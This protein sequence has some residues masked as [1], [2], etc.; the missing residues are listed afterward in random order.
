MFKNYLK[1][2]VRT[3]T[4]NKIYTL[5]NVAGLALGIVCALAIFLII[6][7]QSSFDTYHEDLQ[8]IYRV[9]RTENEFGEINHSP[10]IPYPLPEALRNDFPNIPNLTIVDSNFGPPV[11]SVEKNGTT[12]RFKEKD[13]SV[14]FVNPDYFK[15]F[16]YKWLHGKCFVGLRGRYQNSIEV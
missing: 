14:A 16:K 6:K 4:K 12:F 1:T 2:T 10:G 8:N 9:V 13:N 3:L 15:I 5:I 7:L 11:I